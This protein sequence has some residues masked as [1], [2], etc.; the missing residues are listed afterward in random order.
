MVQQA[1]NDLETVE[2]I[3]NGFTTE[4]R[5]HVCA[6]KLRLSRYPAPL[7]PDKIEAF[8]ELFALRCGQLEKCLGA[9]PFFGGDAPSFSDFC[10]F[11]HYDLATGFRAAAGTPTLNAWA[12]RMRAVPA[13]AAE[14]AERPPAG[15]AAA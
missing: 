12:A 14:I 3:F 9:R 1:A 15:P 11:N 6:L 13:V 5:K 7:Q 10:F 4:A 2:P 8:F